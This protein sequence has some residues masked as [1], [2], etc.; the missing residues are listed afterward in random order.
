MF[1]K[2]LNLH[3]EKQD[4]ILNAALKEFTKKGYQNASTNE[5]VKE[6]EISKGLLFHY[7]NNKKDLYLFLY[8]HFMEMLLEE[9]QAKIDWSENDIFI[10]YRQVAIL[11]FGLFQKYPDAFDFIKAAYPEDASEV[12]VDLERR[13]KELLDQGYKE[14]FADIDYSK[15][16][17]GIDI[18]MTMQIIFWTME[19]FAY[20]LQD[21]VA[22]IPLDQMKI[23]EITAEM[24]SYSEILRNAFYK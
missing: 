16:K 3:P 5:I 12:K 2:F 23:E 10:R 22:T 18:T 7:F 17:E 6:A 13:K 1:A 11:K 24:D 20:H 8:D 15:F 19:G 4:R 14:F 9:I 21:K